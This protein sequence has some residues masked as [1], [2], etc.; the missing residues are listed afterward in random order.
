MGMLELGIT[1]SYTQLLIDAEI[2]RMIKRVLQGM[3]VN[4]DTLAFEVIKAVGAGGNYLNQKHTRQFMKH[5]QS[6]VKLIDRRMR[7][8]WLEKGG[9]GMAEKAREEAVKLLKNHRPQPLEPE[10]SSRLRAIVE[11]ADQGFRLN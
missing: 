10:I 4:E 7:E 6:R 8:R 1:F 3:A 5:E 11:E 9:L 2:V